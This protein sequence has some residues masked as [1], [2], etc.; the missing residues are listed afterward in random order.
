M[1]YTIVAVLVFLYMV[2]LYDTFKTTKQT[3]ETQSE[4]SYKEPYIKTLFDTFLVNNFIYFTLAL[5]AVLVAF[6][7]VTLFELFYLYY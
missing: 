5:P 6:L 7:G 4:L 3:R 1:L 2:C